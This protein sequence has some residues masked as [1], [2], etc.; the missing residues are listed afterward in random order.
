MFNW[1]TI[2]IIVVYYLMVLINYNF[3]LPLLAWNNLLSINALEK[4]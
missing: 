3:I 1:T 4:Y 2:I